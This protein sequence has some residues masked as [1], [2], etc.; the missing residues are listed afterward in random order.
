[1]DPLTYLKELKNAIND[2]PSKV[3]VKSSNSG[4]RGRVQTQTPYGGNH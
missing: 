3:I 4:S 1:M 2:L